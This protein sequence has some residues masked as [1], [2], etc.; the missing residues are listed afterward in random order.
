[1]FWNRLIIGSGEDEWINFRNTCTLLSSYISVQGI[2]NT[3][4]SSQLA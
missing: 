3:P 4:V 1:M 2:K